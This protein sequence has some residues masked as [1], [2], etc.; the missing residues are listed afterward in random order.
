MYVRA[1]FVFPQMSSLG[2]LPSPGSPLS[3]R[4]LTYTTKDVIDKRISV[5]AQHSL[6]RLSKNPTTNADAVG[7]LEEV[8]AARLAGIYCV[9][10]K[11]AAERALR[12]GKSWWTIIPQN[13][14]AI[15]MLDPDNIPG[16]RPLIAFRRELDPRPRVG[17]GLLPNEKPL[18]H[19]PGRLDKALMKV[20][21]SYKLWRRS[22][23]PGGVIQCTTMQ[24]NDHQV[25]SG[26]PIQGSSPVAQLRNVIPRLYCSNRILK[27]RVDCLEPDPMRVRCAG[28]DL[29][30]RLRCLKHFQHCRY[31]P[32]DYGRPPAYSTMTPESM[33]PGFIDPLTDTLIKNQT[34][35]SLQQRL[36]VLIEND[37]GKIKDKIAVALVDLTSDSLLLDPE[38]AGWRETVSPPSAGS[39]A[40][41]CALYALYQLRF[42]L[43]VL[44]RIDP[45]GLRK[46][47]TTKQKLIDRAEQWWDEQGLP[48]SSQ[49]QLNE[50]FDFSENPPAPVSVQL[51][52]SPE[53][54]GLLCCI[55]HQNCNGAADVLVHKLGFPYLA[56]VLWQSGLYSRTRGGLWIMGPFSRFL[57]C[58]RICFRDQIRTDCARFGTINRRSL[59][60][61]IS[62]R[63]FPT[64]NLLNVTALSAATFF[65]LMAQD[66]LGD[67]QTSKNIRWELQP[68]CTFWLGKPNC[69]GF[70]VEELKSSLPRKCG[71]DKIKVKGIERLQLHDVILME[72]KVRGKDIRYVAAL[73]TDGLTGDQESA[74]CFFGKFLTKL[75][76]IIQERHA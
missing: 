11:I 55:F 46:P 5:P 38:F 6:L 76:E 33:N 4:V 50:L 62:G 71:V 54:E 47:I 67:E 23:L 45:D 28:I 49:P 40:K 29:P 14:D 12:F 2:G 44:A 35:D 51:K 26:S 20:W 19:S 73:L 61:V 52:P 41:I 3:P 36:Q 37:Y 60:I 70:G 9:N 48:R 63:K 25:L 32:G 56:S 75:D 57:A 30:P 7:M 22:H 74:K 72:R 15:L 68:T 31:I 13:E 24:V 59:P 21:G 16:G 18:P 69:I 43:D 65:T 27:L 39:L 1:S 58:Q 8:K 34:P 66:R 64:T 10:W 42:D 17:C 53:T